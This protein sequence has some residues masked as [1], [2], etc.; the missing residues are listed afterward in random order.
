MSARFEQGT[1]SSKDLSEVWTEWEGRERVR[2]PALRAR[3]SHRLGTGFKNPAPRPAEIRLPRIR[4]LRMPGDWWLPRWVRKLVDA[5]ASVDDLI[6][7]ALKRVLASP[8]ETTISEAQA[9]VNEL[10]RSPQNASVVRKAFEKAIEE[11]PLGRI[12]RKA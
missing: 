10:S 7:E 8:N 11:T 9:I 3:A 12:L 5:N 2:D 1:I 4:R 6:A